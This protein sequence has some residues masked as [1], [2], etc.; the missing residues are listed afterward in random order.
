M[1]S[2]VQHMFAAL[3]GDSDWLDEDTKHGAKQKL[4]N[5][6]TKIGYPAFILDNEELDAEHEEVDLTRCF[7]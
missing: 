3:L 2:E 5:M 4:F 6:S 1:T 7:F